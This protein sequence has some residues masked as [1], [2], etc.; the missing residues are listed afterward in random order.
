LGISFITIQQIG[1]LLD[2]YKGRTAPLSFLEYSAFVLFFPQLLAGP[3]V[4][5]N[6]IKP[7][8]LRLEEDLM[9]DERLSMAAKGLTYVAIGLFKKTVLAD[10]AARFIQPYFSAATAGEAS[11]ITSV[12]AGMGGTVRVYFDFSGYCDMAIGIGLLFG[13][14]LPINFNAP[15][16]S[17]AFRQFYSSWHITF[18]DFL[19][20]HVFRPLSG[21]IHGTLVRHVLATILIFTLSGLWHGASWNLVLWGLVTGV[22]VVG[23]RVFKLTRY[24]MIPEWLT[25]TFAKLAF[26]FFAILNRTGFPGGILF[27]ELGSDIIVF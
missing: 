7:Q 14:I 20:V 1:Y 11:P 16:R 21:G 6:W 24:V 2:V 3:I 18:H 9:V 19:K 25:F 13:I 23:F 22:L 26:V 15:F 5:A 8:F 27:Q 12:L 4:T 10:E 17:K